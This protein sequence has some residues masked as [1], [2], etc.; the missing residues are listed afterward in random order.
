MKCLVI[1][2]CLLISQL[3]FAQEDVFDLFEEEQAKEYAFATFKG[4]QL[5]NSATNE[6][7]GAVYE[8]YTAVLRMFAC[9]TY[10]ASLHV[11]L[12]ITG[13][14]CECLRVLARM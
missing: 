3:G 4:T 10:S 6:T 12:T 2:L 13:S 14:V 1:T 9:D 7:P 5:V 11:V 8:F